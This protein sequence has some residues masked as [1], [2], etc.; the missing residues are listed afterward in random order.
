MD[1]RKLTR[2]YPPGTR[3]DLCYD[4]RPYGSCQCGC[5]GVTSTMQYADASRGLARYEHRRFI[6][7]HGSRRPGPHFQVD[8]NGCWV[9]LH[10]IQVRGYG[11]AHGK[12]A[13]RV[14][15]EAVN[16]PI[17]DGLQIDHLCENKP[18]VN[19]AHME[20]V[21]MAENLR[22]WREGRVAA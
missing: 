9:W 1:L 6:K 13:H 4:L 16:G 12:L 21:T 14:M 20:P 11:V 10:T 15:Y 3:V 17:P 18:C 7:G 8:A 19:P 2:E 5:G 22:R